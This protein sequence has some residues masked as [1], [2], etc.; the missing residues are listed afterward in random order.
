MPLTLHPEETQYGPRWRILC[1]EVPVGATW[2]LDEPFERSTTRWTWH[3]HTEFSSP[4]QSGG[5][6]ENQD[7]AL[8]R[9]QTAFDENMAL[10]GLTYGQ[11]P[12]PT[13]RLCFGGTWHSEI[14][15]VHS[16]TIDLGAIIKQQSGHGKSWAWY[17]HF[18]H[19]S[20]VVM[21]GSEVTLETAKTA[22]AEHLSRLLLLAGLCGTP[23][24][25]ERP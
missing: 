2:E 3:L 15:A 12:R 24:G 6:A 7:A 19:D 1:G 17:L 25:N 23:D 13:L 4:V 14:Y 21:S 22:L 8:A 20:P 10:A 16:G 11:G 5:Y 18:T 9:A